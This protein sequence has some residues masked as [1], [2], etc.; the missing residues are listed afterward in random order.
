MPGPYTVF[1]RT[2]CDTPGMYA[3][4][5]YSFNSQGTAHLAAWW[6]SQ[7]Y[8][9]APCAIFVNDEGNGHDPGWEKMTSRC[10]TGKFLEL[11]KAMSAAGWVV[12][13]IDVPASAK[14]E[15]SLLGWNPGVEGGFRLLGTWAEHTPVAMWPEQAAYVAEAV[16]YVRSNWCAIDG[17]D[18]MPFGR[19]LL[20]VGNSINPAQIVLC[21]N[22]HGATMAMFVSLIPDGLY[23]FEGSFLHDGM[24]PHVPR[25]SHRVDKIVAIDPCID[26]G[27]LYIDPGF[28]SPAPT[29]LHRDCWGIFQRSEDRRPYSELPGL[30]KRADP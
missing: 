8:E 25:A 1:D 10:F 9:D 24:D 21:G 29:E 22:K 4:H 20:G 27:Q 5:E 18:E 6:P 19:E 26:F 2:N 28:D 13:S 17:P 14:N 3:K 16:Q 30:F 15:S 23:Q 7:H 11:A 12:I